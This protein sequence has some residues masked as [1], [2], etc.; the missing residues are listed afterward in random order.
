VAI[1]DP[2]VLSP[3]ALLVPVAE[4]AEDVRSRFE[5][6]EGDF[7]LTH[8]RLRAPSRILNARS[9]ELLERFRS[10]R[11]I[12]DVVLEYSR[13]QGADPETTLN[14][15]YP[16]LQ[17]LFESGFLVAEGT[18]EAEGIFASL[19]P[20]EA[21]GGFEVRECV[22]ELEDTDLY[23][24]WGPEGAVALKIERTPRDWTSV[25][26]AW[27]A[28]V[29]E[30]LQGNPAPRLLRTGE[31]E[32]RRWL[33][34]EWCPGVD[35]AAAA[36]E[37]RRCG[38]SGRRALLALCR[39][40]GSAYV[41]LHAR[42]VLHGD[43]HPRNVL[44]AGDGTVRLVDFGHARWDEA[45]TALHR[46]GRAGIA[47]FFEPEYA[48]ASL[49]GRPLPEASAVGE[50]YAV[51]AL[52]YFLIAGAHYR[53]FQL[54]RE[55]MLRQIA[56][57]PPLPFAERGAQPW[58]EVE[59]VLERAL[60]KPPGG[61]F[62][63]LA[64][65]EE[66]FAGIEPPAAEPAPLAT[67]TGDLLLARVL[68]R[69]KPGGDLF[70]D[71][72]PEP[73]RVSLNF[74]S[75]GIGHALYRIALAREDAALLSL[76]DL[77][78]AR[79]VAA[80]TA[81]EGFYAPAKG[82]GQDTVG[83]VSPYHT[84]TGPFCVQALI[85]HVLGFPALQRPAVKAFLGAAREPCAERD[86]TLG[87]SGLL[88]AAALLLDAR[89]G[90]AGD[91][92][93]DALTGFGDELLAGL[94]SELDLLPAI[95]EN[96]ERPALG[97]AHGWAGYLYAS[98]QWC[99]AAGRPQPARLAERLDELAACAR[100]WGRGLRWRWR[101]G[102]SRW[103]VGS[104]PGWCNGSAGFVFLWALAHRMLGDARWARLAEGAAWNAWESSGQSA[105]LCCGLAGRAY[106]LL[107]LHRHGGGAE[108]LQRARELGERAAIAAME[109][110][111]EPEP[112]HSL[113]RGEVGVA[114]L[115]ADLAHSQQAAMPF[116]EEEGWP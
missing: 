79:A 75:A 95:R 20:G 52:L 18:P 80:G 85:A 110:A 58:P 47:F 84:P 27:E 66:A 109:A 43:V 5:H 74:G 59:A 76:A 1:T 34:L 97:M 104:M 69:V 48:A 44:V 4:L 11:R 36:G 99:R 23:Q 26:F 49:A 103:S 83:R 17:G 62:P 61:R 112:S 31:A 91:P 92:V 16:L 88:L 9:A 33:A 71:G 86:L 29:L 25:R 54:D 64:A 55:A 14:E 100:P 102:E 89:S 57:E 13:L 78:A 68:A 51:A 22:Q 113:Y 65:L 87:R 8:P 107:N 108:W 96:Q 101:G 111:A 42:G 73:P 37:L 105:S 35:A 28:A 15:A 60:A 45:P 46:P 12:V 53:D 6:A 7:A 67:P 19:L 41:R 77:W 72:I 70:R 93:L 98:L 81:D 40:I 30:Q 63:S 106:A 2:V 24:A 82:L 39:A 21:I 3:A 115:I 56:A 32:G 38:P 94:W 90:L 10:P 116:F 50:Q 114:V